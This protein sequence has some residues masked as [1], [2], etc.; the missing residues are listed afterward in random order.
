MRHHG[1]NVLKYQE[2]GEKRRVLPLN[3]MESGISRARE[4]HLDAWHPTQHKHGRG[5]SAPWQ[6]RLDGQEDRAAA[7]AAEHRQAAQEWDA[8]KQQLGVMPDMPREAFLARVYEATRAYRPERRLTPAELAVEAPLVEQQRHVVHQMA[9]VVLVEQARQRTGQE[10]SAAAAQRQQTVW[11]QAAALGLGREARDLTHRW[12]KPLI[13]HRESLIYHTPEHKNY[14]DVHPKHQVHFWTEQQAIDAGYRRA[15]NDHYGRGTGEVMM[16]EERQ[17]R[18]ETPRHAPSGGVG[19]TPRTP[20]EDRVAAIRARQASRGL[21]AA[22]D[23]LEDDAPQG[24]VK[25]RLH[26]KEHDRGYSY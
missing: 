3:P 5:T 14:G 20:L 13:G 23:Q 4:A 6:Q 9:T 18:R 24:G 16:V 11:Q 19:R 1:G 12:E 7:R 25:V 17:G 2:Y 26:D 10:R 22:L 21:A 15:A 8:R